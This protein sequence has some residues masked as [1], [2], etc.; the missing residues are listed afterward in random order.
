MPPRKPTRSQIRRLCA[1]PGPGDGLDPRDEPRAGTSPRRPARKRS[2]LCRQVAETLNEALASQRD[3]A[4]RDLEV[5]A[6]EPGPDPT[7]LLVTVRPLPGAP[8][9][10]AALLDRLERARGRLRTEIAAAITR[11]R[12]PEIDWRLALR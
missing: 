6:V 1:E 10:P 9:D 7:R 2:Q 12:T 4:L 8:D 3:D 5:I 11:R